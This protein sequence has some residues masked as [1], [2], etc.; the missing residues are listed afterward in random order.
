MKRGTKPLVEADPELNVVSL[1]K[2]GRR[3]GRMNNGGSK[4]FDSERPTEVGIKPSYDENGILKSL[5]IYDPTGD[6]IK[7]I[8]KDRQSTARYIRAEYPGVGYDDLEDAS[9]VYDLYKIYVRLSR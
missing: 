4:V 3:N 9:I 7:R 2:K 5:V 1:R 6:I 8:R